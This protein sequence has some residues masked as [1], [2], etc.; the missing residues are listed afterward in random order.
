MHV[1]VG[2][3]MFVCVLHLETHSLLKHLA[4]KESVSV[5]QIIDSR[6][7]NIHAY[8]TLESKLEWTN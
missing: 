3:C 5:S 1:N 6:A 7:K 4:N 2:C 8:F